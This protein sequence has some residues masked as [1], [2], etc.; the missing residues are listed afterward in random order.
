MN[1]E[2]KNAYDSIIEK[3]QDLCYDYYCEHYTKPN[4]VLINEHDYA[5]L[6]TYARAV[7]GSKTK[8]KQGDFVYTL[9]GLKI[10]PIKEGEMRVVEL[11]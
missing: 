11:L 9:T 5:I 10:I 3:V 4:A 2:P 7:L 6:M 1:E 8:L